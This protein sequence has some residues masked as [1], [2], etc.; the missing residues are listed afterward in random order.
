MCQV[1]SDQRLF[2]TLYPKGAERQ[3]LSLTPLLGGLLAGAAGSAKALDQPLATHRA[4]VAALNK[5]SALY[6]AGH[7]LFAFATVHLNLRGLRGFRGVGSAHRSLLHYLIPQRSMGVKKKTPTDVS[8]G[9]WGVGSGVV[10]Y[11][12]GSSRRALASE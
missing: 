8:E 7:T 12:V 1:V 11:S 3:K 9:A 4:D 2:T 10:S 6:F 5:H